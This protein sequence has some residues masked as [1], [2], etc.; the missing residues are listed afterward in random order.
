RCGG[1]MTLRE[2][3]A[4]DDVE[5]L[6]QGPATLQ[7]EPAGTLTR[8]PD[9]A[10]P[11]EVSMAPEWLGRRFDPS[12]STDASPSDLA[13]ALQALKRVGRFEVRECLGLG[14]F[15]A[16]YRVWD[17]VLK[18]EV[19]VKLL[20][21]DRVGSTTQTAAVLRE[22]RQAAKLRHPGIVPVHEVGV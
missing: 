6:L 13:A 8:P 15:G 17:P 9:S 19:A 14:G 20:H 16:V 3:T 11:A 4:A 7:S 1:P 12:V 22:A 5:R 2:V 10:L 18:R 21:L